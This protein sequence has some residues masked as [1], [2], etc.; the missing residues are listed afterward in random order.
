MKYVFITGA[1]GGLGRAC[2]KAFTDAGYTVFAADISPIDGANSQPNVTNS[3]VGVTNSGVGVTNSKPT[4]TISQPNVTN[5]G[6]GVTNSKPTNTISQPNVTNL[7]VGVTNSGVGATNEVGVACADVGKTKGCGRLVELIC[8]ITSEESVGA[9]VALVGATTDRLDAVVSLAGTAAI[10]SLVESDAQV[11]KTAMDVNLLGMYRTCRAFFPLVR[12]AKGRY[13][14]I[15][16]EYGVLTAVPFH[17]FYTASKRA[18]EAY[19]DSLRREML[20]H[21]IKVIIIRPGAFKT[22]MQNGIGNQFDRLIG[23]TEFYKLPLS[24][25]KSLMSGELKRAAEPPVLARAILRAAEA[26]RPKRVY[27]VNNSFKM[28]LLTVLPDGIQDR[29]FKRF[30]QK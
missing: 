6:V 19:S 5:S 7:A 4:N 1:R 3:G 14:N 27:R 23:T 26:K 8:D 13:I 28:K 17:G 21:D 9:A 16:S 2:V 11:M 12:R 15:S 25:M 10:G 30:M 24:K 20:F 22:P 18:V 29:I